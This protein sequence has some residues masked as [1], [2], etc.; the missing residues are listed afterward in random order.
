MTREPISVQALIVTHGRASWLNRCI[1]SLTRAADHCDEIRLSF[2]LGVNGS[3]PQTSQT[4]DELKLPFIAVEPT[5]PAEARNKLFASMTGEW[6]LFI[7]DD[8]FVAPDFF[9]CFLM[10][11]KSFPKSDAIGGPNLTHVDSS[12]FQRATG[13]ALASRFATFLSYARYR[14]TGP[15]RAC[16]ESALILCNLFVRRSALG[17]LRFPSHI[18]CAEENWLLAR[19]SEQG[20][21]LVYAPALWVWHER[22]EGFYALAGQ[23]FKYGRGRGQSLRLGLGAIRVTHVLPSLC[24]FYTAAF[25]AAF[26]LGAT[27]LLPGATPFLVYAA[28]CAWFAATR[29]DSFLTAILIFPLIH[30]AYGVGIIVGLLIPASVRR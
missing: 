29:T 27:D 1:N 22:R 14:A 4:L 23:V 9:E 13:Q 18:V 6:I 2:S 20:A 7:D 12:P 24:L 16:N 21:Q 26:C 19:M 8:A 30:C 25:A 17:A 28:L 11:L 10:A 5:T 15:L 3:D